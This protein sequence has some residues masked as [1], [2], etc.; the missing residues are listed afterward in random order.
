MAVGLGFGDNT[1]SSLITRGLAET[2][3]LGIA[4]GADPHDVLGL[5]G[6]GD[7]VAT[8][9]SPL[10]RNRTFGENL[11]QGPARSRR[12]QRLTR[13]TCEGVKSCQSILDLAHKHG[14]DMPITEQVVEVVAPRCLAQ[15]DAR[16]S[17]VARG[18]GR[19]RLTAQRRRRR[20]TVG[21]DEAC[22]ARRGRSRHRSST[23]SMPTD[24]R[25]SES[26]HVR[27]L[28]RPARR[29]SRVDSTPPRLVVCTHEPYGV[30]D[31][32][33]VVGPTDDLEAERSSRSRPTARPPPRWPGSSGSPG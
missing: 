13:Q 4:L 12:P 29:R 11:G 25:I 22:R 23:S 8:C 24:S 18:Q 7:L 15:R 6:I 28:G 5:A 3:R 31:P 16:A 26:G 1:Q 17:H 19:G 30:A 27:A 33:G 10:S 32:L 9:T 20:V 14:V 21:S 2:A